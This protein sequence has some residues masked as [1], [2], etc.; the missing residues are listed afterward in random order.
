MVGVD[1]QESNVSVDFDIT[2]I[3]AGVCGLA[4]AAQVA[5]GQRSVVVVEKNAT[6]GLET[7]S[8]NSQ[9][10]HAGMYYPEGSWKARTCVEGNS[11]LYDIC[12]QHRIAHQKPGKLIVAAD[13]DE[14]HQLESLWEQGRRNGIED[15][16]MLNAKDV[17]KM[18]PNVRA[19][20]ALLSPSTGIVDAYG[21][22][23]YFLA[24][25]KD[26]GVDAVYKTQ[27]MGIEKRKSQ[28]WISI[29]DA[30]GV[31][32]FSTTVLINA[33]GLQ[34][35]KVAALGGINV[36]EAGYKLYYCKGEYFKLGPGKGKLINKLVYPVPN[37]A[38]AGLGIHVTPSI[39]GMVLLGPNE[40]Y[41]EHIDYSVDERHKQDFATAVATFL[42]QI[43][44][45]DLEPEMAGIRP[46]LQEPGGIFRDFVIKHEYDHG[47]AGFINLI[48]IESPG[49][50]ASPAI[51]RHVGIMVDEALR[52]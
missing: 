3:G 28:Y 19:T 38:G 13:K 6:Y 39:E 21:L 23:R 50:T 31:S 42:P 35:D 15:L 1:G 45:D 7:S 48:G 26:G 24:R 49:L 25:A 2:I 29:E 27:V 22:M 36:V 4:I 41:V 10:I 5:D 40:C 52:D 14:I 12:R 17:G 46:K 33:A 37:P 9:V 16:E 18:E 51:A 32:C 11:L 30:S 44:A 43:H 8:R 34:S 47:L 20:A